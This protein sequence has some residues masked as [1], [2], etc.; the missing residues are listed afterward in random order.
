MVLLWVSF[1]N[2]QRYSFAL[3]WALFSREGSRHEH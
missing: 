1:V 2:P 3:R